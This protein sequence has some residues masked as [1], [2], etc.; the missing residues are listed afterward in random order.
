MPTASTHSSVLGVIAWACSGL[1]FL[2]LLRLP[3][4]YYTF[5]RMAVTTGAVVLL[6]H[7]GRGGAVGWWMLFFTV[8]ALVFNPIWPVYLHDRA[9]WAPINVVSGILFLAAGL[10]L[11]AGAVK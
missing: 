8:V 7:Y 3:I 4:G 2:A 9:L 10:R 1:L 11:N 5:L 6:Y